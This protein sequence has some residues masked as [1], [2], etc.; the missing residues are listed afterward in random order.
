MKVFTIMV[1]KPRRLPGFLA[2]AALNRLPGLRGWTAG[3]MANEKEHALVLI[4]ATVPH[5]EDGVARLFLRGWRV[6]QVVMN[7]DIDEEA[8]RLHVHDPVG[9][10]DSVDPERLERNENGEPVHCWDYLRNR[11]EIEWPAGRP[12]PEALKQK[13]MNWP[14]ADPKQGQEKRQR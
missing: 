2:R 9:G 10:W 6:G 13:R 3:E 7:A 12:V 4:F 8:R 1:Q 5:A 14:G 11:R